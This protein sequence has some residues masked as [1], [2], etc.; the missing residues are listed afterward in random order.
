MIISNYISNILS[1]TTRKSSLI[2]FS[3]KPVSIVLGL[4]YTPLLLQYLGDEKYGLWATIISVISWINYCDIGVGNG[5][6]NL[7]TRELTQ[8]KYEE[9]RKSVSTGYIVLVVISGILLLISIICLLTLNWHKIFNTDID[10]QLPLGISFAFIC[11]NFVL[12]LSNSLLYSLQLSERIAL[13]SCL[14]QIINIIGLLILNSVSDGSLVLLSILFGMS[15]MSVYIYNTISIIKKHSYLRPDIRL[16]EKRKISSICNVGIKFF[17]I[18]I[19]CIALFTVDNI[20]ITYL[21]GAEHVT[22]FNIT[23]TI[24]NT[25]FAFFT[26][27]AIPYWSKSTEAFTRRDYKWISSS[28]KR[29]N[30]LAVFFCI[31]YVI[32]ALLF[33]HITFIWLGRDLDYPYGLTTVMCVFYCL[34]SFVTANIQFINGS[35]K[36]NFQLILMTFMGIANIPF[37]IYLATTYDLGV[38]GI[39]LAT[40]LL[41]F[42]AA[43]AFPINLW[44]ILKK[45]KEH[46]TEL[47][48][49]TGG[50]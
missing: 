49:N 30:I 22:P 50:N 8:K 38:V 39:R 33:K 15:T 41:M 25:C 1:D 10:M 24:F 9:V 2:N 3:L 7:V 14:V 48:I 32:V 46:F 17:I 35:G 31:G 29:L 6:R 36:I 20:L 11:V 45:E 4:I 12:A 42:I 47:S 23:Y 26:A 27:L 5:L 16:F 18:Q 43:V 21:F 44:F 28:I 34:Y 40:T 37:S 19:D 13:R